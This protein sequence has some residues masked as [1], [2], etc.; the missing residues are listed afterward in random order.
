VI[1][2]I[3]TGGQT[4]ADQAAVRAGHAAGIPTGGFAPKGWLTEDGPAPGSLATALSSATVRATRRAPRPTSGRPTW[5]WESA[6]R[7]RRAAS[8]R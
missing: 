3:I 6:T 2:G 1:A 8:S 4:G 7:P 5:F